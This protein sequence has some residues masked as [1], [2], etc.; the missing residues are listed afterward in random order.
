MRHQNSYNILHRNRKINS[1]IYS[2][3]QNIPN[4]QINPEQVS[5]AGGHTK[6]NFKL[7]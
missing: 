2:K 3:A 7:Y 4:N 1:K 5:N 6:P